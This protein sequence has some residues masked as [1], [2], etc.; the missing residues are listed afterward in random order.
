MLPTLRLCESLSEFVEFRNMVRL[1]LVRLF[2]CRFQ[3]VGDEKK[4]LVDCV[5]SAGR[6]GGNWSSGGFRSGGSG[7]L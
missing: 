2:D 6:V 5:Y 3:S 7:D 4:G 1:N